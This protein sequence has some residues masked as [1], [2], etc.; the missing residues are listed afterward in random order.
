MKYVKQISGLI[1]IGISFYSISQPQ[2]YTLLTGTAKNNI[3]TK[4]KTASQNISSMQCKFVQ[5]KTSTLFSEQAVSKGIL[6]YKSPDFLRWQYTE[7]NPL[8]LIFRENNAFIQNEKGT[9][10]NSNKML[11]Q[12]GNLIISNING[13][14][15]TDNGNFKIDYYANEN[16]KS[17]LWIKLTPVAKR[18]KE[19][20]TSIQIKIATVDYLAM[21]IIMEEISG[22]KTTIT[23]SDKKINIIISDNQFSIN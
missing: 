9:F 18:L 1:L 19:M 15:L 4:I 14:G 5:K 7:P 12:L 8:V 6:F 2:N 17:I 13:K 23:F 11:K 10:I 20:Y 3:E 22:D 16:D 21:E